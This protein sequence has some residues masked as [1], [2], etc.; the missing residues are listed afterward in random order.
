MFETIAE[1]FDRLAGA[2][3][4]K[5]DAVPSDRLDAPSPCEGWSALDVVRHV[6][7]TPAV[8]YGF[9]GKEADPIPPVE[10]DP[11][12]AF[13]AMRRQMQATLDDAELAITEFD[14][15]FGRTT[16]EQAADRFVNTDLVVHGWDLAR[17]AGLDDRMDLADVE[18]IDRVTAQFG[19]AARAPGVFG[20]AL[21]AP[22]DAD[23]QTKVL[24]FVGRRA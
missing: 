14:G 20:P 9:I 1:R 15:F 21:E 6:A 8:F 19:D 12:A 7:E 3:A 4:A 2:F 11:A 17:A 16:F 18:R 10:D 24:A 23:L 5:I 22:P 13:A